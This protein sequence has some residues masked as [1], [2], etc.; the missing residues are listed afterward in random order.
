MYIKVELSW[1][2]KINGHVVPPFNP[3]PITTPKGFGME[4][5]HG[6]ACV[7]TGAL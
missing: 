6:Y 4:Y 5:C 3:I 7:F 2:T 1:D